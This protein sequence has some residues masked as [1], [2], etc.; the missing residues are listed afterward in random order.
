MIIYNNA[1]KINK[2]QHF[3]LFLLR[4]LFK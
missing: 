3:T 1:T 4:Q 2:N